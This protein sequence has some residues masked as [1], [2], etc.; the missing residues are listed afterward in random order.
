M[1]H[2][3][4]LIIDTEGKRKSYFLWNGTETYY[5]KLRSAYKDI[6]S[7][8]TNDYSFFSFFILCSATLE[9]SLNYIIADFGLKHY[10]PDKCDTFPDKYNKLT[11]DFIWR[12]FKEKIRPEE[13][14]VVRKTVTPLQHQRQIGSLNKDSLVLFL[15]V[16]K[17]SINHSTIEGKISYQHNM[18]GYFEHPSNRKNIVW[19]VSI[20]SPGLAPIPKDVILVPEQIPGP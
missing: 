1:D 18:I 2:A 5:E 6:E 14:W 4:R 19:M 10:G 17:D 7:D 8:K 9:Y 12:K 16:D 20:V 3:G 13:I 11:E 15:A